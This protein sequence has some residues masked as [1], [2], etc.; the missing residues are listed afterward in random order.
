MDRPSY[1]LEYHIIGAK[2]SHMVSGHHPNIS[3]D[4]LYGHRSCSCIVTHRGI[5]IFSLTNELCQLHHIALKTGM[6][7]WHLET[8]QG[9]GGGRMRKGEGEREK[10]RERGGI[11]RIREGGENK[12]EKR[13]RKKNL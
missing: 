1:H 3:F 5:H 8:E 2:T 4:N 12:R 6:H 9:R 10:G 11:G 7:Q 13:S